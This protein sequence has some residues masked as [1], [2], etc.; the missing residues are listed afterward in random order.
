MEKAEQTENQYIDSSASTAQY[1]APCV[2]SH[3]Q[4]F[5]RWQ[6]ENGQWHLEI[7]DVI[8]DGI[9]SNGRIVVADMSVWVVLQVDH[10]K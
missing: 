8:E 2:T 1:L 4:T 3:Q 9:W 6:S 7:S 5:G 10:F